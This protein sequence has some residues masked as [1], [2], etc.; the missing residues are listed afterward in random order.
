[1]LTH[2]RTHT[3]TYTHTHTQ[4]LDALLFSLSLKSMGAACVRS[5]EKP[6]G[7]YPL[8]YSK[9]LFRVIFFAFWLSSHLTSLPTHFLSFSLSPSLLLSPLSPLS[10]S[11]AAFTPWTQIKMARYPSQRSHTY[12][13]VDLASRSLLHRFRE[14]S[15]S[16]P[17]G[18]CAWLM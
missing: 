1:M 16:D 4:V 10:L 9:V 12:C 8:L 5:S 13:T 14:C 18:V 2:I 7:P 11:P 6:S 3:H 15:Q 17:M